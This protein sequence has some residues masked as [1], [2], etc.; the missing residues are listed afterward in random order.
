METFTLLIDQLLIRFYRLTGNAGVDFVLGTF[1][2][3]CLCLLIGEI[4][5][6]FVFK[7]GR[8]H[9]EKR[10]E[11]ATSYQNLSVNALKAGDKEAYQA[12][13]ELANEAFSHT[14]FQQMALS[15]AFLWPVCFAL[16][17]MQQRFLE[18]EF[19]IPGT[20]WSL[21]FIGVFIIVYAATYFLF[22]KVKSRLT[23]FRRDRE[24]PVTIPP[25]TVK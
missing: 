22:K 3:A 19:P 5:L 11:E 17:W 1:I 18:M 2:L 21:G 12:A 25:E 9:I 8:R 10:V 13:N 6:S 23:I 20:D 15:G 7:I 24:N 16:A 4:T 14:F